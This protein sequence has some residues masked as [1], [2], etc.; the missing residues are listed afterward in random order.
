LRK[1]ID[2]KLAS[3]I[4]TYKDKREHYPP[5]MRRVLELIDIE[6]KNRSTVNGEILRIQQDVRQKVTELEADIREMDCYSG[7]L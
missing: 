2:E 4:S 5:S 7:R 3:R 6:M 1:E